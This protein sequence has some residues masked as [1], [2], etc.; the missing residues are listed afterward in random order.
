MS[1]GGA[2]PTPAPTPTPTPTPTPAPAKT[3]TPA[4]P[5]DGDYSGLFILIL[6]NPITWTIVSAVAFCITF[7]LGFYSSRVDLN[8]LDPSNLKLWW[9]GTL[10]SSVIFLLLFYIVFNKSSFNRAMVFL[11]LVAVLIVHVSL[12]LTQMNLSV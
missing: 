9:V 2:V 11:L 10:I 6:T 3:A 5:S 4:K 12:L 8:A 1:S 7:S